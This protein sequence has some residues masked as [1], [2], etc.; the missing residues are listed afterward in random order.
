MPVS[1]GN[2]PAVLEATSPE[3]IEQARALFIQYASSLGFSLCF[4][5]FDEELKDLPG[6]YAP[7]AGCLLLAFQEGQP[8]GC[9][10]LRPLESGICEMKRLYVRPALRGKGA[11]KVLVDRII[12]EARRIG[13][14]RMRLDT[15]TSSMQDAIALYG[16]RGFQEIPPYRENPIAGALYLELVL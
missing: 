5:G 7:P 6:A 10:A 12:A 8:A 9:V 14:Q 16:R 1:L 13:Y 15:I 4:Q 2:A 3:Q 11:G